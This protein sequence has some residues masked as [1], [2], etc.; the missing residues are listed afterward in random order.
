LVA[1]ERYPASRCKREFNIKTERILDTFV[2]HETVSVELSLVELSIVAALIGKL[3]SSA[4]MWHPC[5]RSAS[6]LR[7]PSDGLGIVPRNDDF[8]EGIGYYG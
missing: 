4:A 3:K 7:S 5:P 8:D 6:V 1:I 2:L